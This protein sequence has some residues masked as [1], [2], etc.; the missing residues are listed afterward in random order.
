MA[1]QVASSSLFVRLMSASVAIANHAGHII[2][3][4]MRKGNLGIVEKVCI[5]IFI[6]RIIMS[7]RFQFFFQFKSI[8][9]ILNFFTPVLNILFNKYKNNVSET[10][11]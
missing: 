9:F 6:I 2:R 7:L 11:Q 1:A 3:E 5:L 10:F 8:L 4:I